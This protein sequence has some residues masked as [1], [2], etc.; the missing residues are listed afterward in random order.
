MTIQLM[1]PVSK[2]KA[3]ACGGCPP[4]SC[5]LLSARKWSTIGSHTGI[6]PIFLQTPR[7]HEPCAS[8]HWSTWSCFKQKLMRLSWSMCVVNAIQTTTKQM[9]LV[10]AYSNCFLHCCVSARTC[11]GR[12]GL[13]LGTVVLYKPVLLS[14]HLRVILTCQLWS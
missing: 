4:S 13:L 11:W 1:F 8:H 9:P 3:K 10:R 14:I 2:S 12:G 7:P 5:P 6:N